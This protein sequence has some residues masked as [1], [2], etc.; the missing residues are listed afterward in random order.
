MDL[1]C[2]GPYTTG[3]RL[4][5]ALRGILPSI[6]LTTYPL[7]PISLGSHRLVHSAVSYPKQILT[8]LVVFLVVFLL[9]TFFTLVLSCVPIAAN[10]NFDLRPP[11]IGTGN[12]RCLTTET[13]RN[14]AFVNSSKFWILTI[15]SSLLTMI[16]T[17]IVT[18]IVLAVIPVP[19]IWTLQVNK[20]TKASLI[21]I[22]TLGFL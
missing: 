14:I 9:F 6:A 7:S 21:F 11:P 20:R 17:N 22:L 13:Y 8:I 12:A 18:D 4:C 15:Q 3:C 2:L 16:V 5:E 1:H 19:L 10:W